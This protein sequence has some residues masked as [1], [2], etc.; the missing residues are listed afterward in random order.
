MSLDKI[1]QYV[2][3]LRAIREYPK[4]L[5]ELL[6]TK[7][8]CLALVQLHHDSIKAWENEKFELEL[9]LAMAEEQRDELIF[10]YENRE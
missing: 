6:E 1:D 10:K 9:K 4:L 2:S 7:R 5:N 3:E 8:D